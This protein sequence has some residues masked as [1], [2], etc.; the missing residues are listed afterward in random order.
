LAKTTQAIV[1]LM[2]DTPEITIPEVAEKLGRSERAIEL[3]INKLKES[4]VITRVGP[5]KGGHWQVAE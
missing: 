1:D 3:Q 5:A 2:L 4:Q